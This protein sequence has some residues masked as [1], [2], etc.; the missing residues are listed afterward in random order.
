MS[1][2]YMVERLR[3]LLRWREYLE[4]LRRALKEAFPECKAYIVGS[5]P[6]GRLTALSDIDVL[7][8]C[9]EKMK[10]SEFAKRTA[11]V[12]ERLEEEGIEW[13]FLFE[14]HQIT[15]ERLKETLEEPYVELT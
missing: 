2:E 10:L 8:V 7:I 11:K 5:A 12:R 14:F 13:S 9:K 1:S 4:P 6:K 3:A 15:E